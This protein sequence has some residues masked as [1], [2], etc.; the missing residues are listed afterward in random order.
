MP[1]CIVP[2]TALFQALRGDAIVDTTALTVCDNRR[3]HSH[4]VFE[5]HAAR[6]KTSTGWFYGFKLHLIINSQGELLRI[7]P[8]PGNTDDRKPLPELCEGLFGQRFADKGSV[9]R[10]LTEALADQAESY[11]P[12]P[13]VFRGALKAVMYRRRGNGSLSRGD[14][15]LAQGTD[16]VARRVQAMDGGA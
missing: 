2:L 7:Q 14:A 12:M 4:R 10:W 16:Y 8:T 6:G 3:I 1:R 5:H 13:P 9:A 11:C 15:D